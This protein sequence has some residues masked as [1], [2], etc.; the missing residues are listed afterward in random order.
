MKNRVIVLLLLLIISCSAFNY[1]NSSLVKKRCDIEPDKVQPFIDFMN[2]TIP[3][4]K[5]KYHVEFHFNSEKCFLHRFNIQD[6]TEKNVSSYFDKNFE[7]VNGHIYHFY[8]FHEF[9]FSNIAYID[10]NGNPTFFEAVNCKDRGD[11]F[12]DVL[13]F[14]EINLSNNSNKEEIIQRVYNYRDYM[15]NGGI[16]DIPVNIK[17]DCDPC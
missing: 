4:F 13:N 3:D 8:A 11:S 7:I 17:C 14:I 12:K 15:I 5:E 10:S 1:N 2:K 16:D 6:L 9:A